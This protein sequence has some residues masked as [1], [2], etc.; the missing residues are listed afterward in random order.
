MAVS[1]L[2][3]SVAI[4]VLGPSG[5]GL[6]RRIKAL[7]PGA[8]IHAPAARRIDADLVF[9][10]ATDHLAA[11]FAAGTPIVALCASGI[12]VR[13]L[14][15]LLAAKREEPAVVAVAEDGS[16]AVPLL[17][18]HRGA[19]ALA[20]AIA[21]MTGG[22][23]AITTAGDLR[24]DL[25]LDEPPPGWRVA[26][27]E[28]AK[29]VMAALLAGEPVSLTVEAGDAAWLEASGAR[30]AQSATARIRIT[31]RAASA[32]EQALVLHPPVLALGVGCERGIAA[33]EMHALVTETLRRNGLAAGA[34]ALIA[35]LDLKSAEP[36][37]HALAQALD[38]PARFFSA[39]ELLAETPRLQ[40]P[41]EAV[42]RAVGCYGVAE[43]AALA[44]AG[45]DATL[46]VP[47]PAEGRVTCAVAR[48]PAALDPPK[49]G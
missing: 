47:K 16:A 49:I 3:E 23:A 18:G 29:P 15:P 24:F 28:C 41:S 44:A 31:D 48:A 39:H 45:P 2:P 6:A 42:L 21:A 35:S 14:A 19:N 43:G 22:V 11:L 13:A 30:F 32:D 5:L 4:V 38:V 17:G 7:L 12:V 8:A 20:R 27:P 10:K 33:E 1:V 40:T 26:N 37:V 34:V 46:L 9:G 25:A 36:A